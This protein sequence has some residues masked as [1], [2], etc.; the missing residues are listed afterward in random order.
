MMMS[1]FVVMVMAATCA[2]FVMVM[3]IVVVMFMMFVMMMFMA[4]FM[5]F[6]FMVMMSTAAFF[7]MIVMMVFVIV[8][9]S[10]ATFFIMIVM[11]FMFVLMVMTST[12]AMFIVVMVM[13]MCMMGLQLSIPL[14]STGKR[15]AGITE[16]KLARQAAENSLADARDGL[17]VQHKQ[18]RYNLSSAYEDFDT[19]KMNIDVSQRV[20]ESTSNKFEYG[21]A[22]SLELTNASMT[23]LTAQS[24]YIQSILTG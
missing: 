10:T 18:L 7:I 13:M 12:F 16:K 21:H 23:L 5:F 19:Q 2:V 11:M 8:M 14:W 4:A 1:M 24:D 22:S 17:L 9:V 15:A 3:M 20:F 6:V